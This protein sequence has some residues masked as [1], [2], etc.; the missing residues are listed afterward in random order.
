M[1]RENRS[2]LIKSIVLSVALIVSLGVTQPIYT[3]TTQAAAIEDCDL[4]GYDD[5]T[6][7]PVPWIGFDSTKGE[8]VPSDWDHKTIYKSRKAYEDAHKKEEV[9]E[10]PTK[11]SSASPNNNA[12]NINTNTNSNTGNSS[13][14]NS[15][16]SKKTT[17]NNTSKKTTNNTSKKTSNNTSKNNNTN[18]V[19]NTEVNNSEEAPEQTQEEQ[20][21][22]I[23]DADKTKKKKKKKSAKS[24]DTTTEEIEEIPV[25]NQNVE[26]IAGEVK[27]A[28]AEGSMIHA[29]GDLVITGSGFTGNV[30]DIEVEI[31]SDNAISLGNFNT[32]EDGSFEAVVSI[33]ENLPAGLHEIVL[34]YQGETIASESIQ[35]GEKVADTFLAALTTGFSAENKGFIPGV[36]ILAGLFVVG[37]LTAVLGNI[38]H[39]KK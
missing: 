4:D 12:N 37:A 1:R 31:H 29:G 23:T 2:K 18:S 20:T 34:K 36:L 15:T 28:D 17:A 13:T 27:I 10:A 30:E 14:N 35:V 11:A 22:E 25:E 8:E 7:N 26:V 39:R 16:A 5:H 38:F 6:G 24:D 3:V 21:E 32:L 9:T 19:T 33:P